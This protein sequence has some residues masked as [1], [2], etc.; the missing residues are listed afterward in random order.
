VAPP[1]ASPDEEPSPSRLHAGLEILKDNFEAFTVALI[2][3]LVIKHFCVEAFKIPTGSMY[4]TLYGENTSP[5]NVGDRILVD[6][7]A[8]LTSGPERW[9]VIVFRYPL[10]WS[11]HFI[12]RVAGL[13]GEWIKTGYGDLWTRTSEDE[14]WRIATKR[15]RVRD[16]L[17]LPVYPPEPDEYD[18]RPPP[19]PSRYWE[20]EGGWSVEDHQTLR[21]A[22]GDAGS[23]VFLKRIG[24]TT[25]PTSHSLEGD[26]DLVRDVRVL[27]TLTPQAQSTFTLSWRAAED[28]AAVVRLAPPGAATGGHVSTWNADGMELVKPL[29]V[30]LAPGRA[31]KLE[32]ECVDGEVYVHLDGEEIAHLDEAR[33]IEDIR[34]IQDYMQELKL[35]AEGGAVFVGDVRIERDV[36]YRAKE[37]YE[38][39]SGGTGVR[40]PEG[41]YF[42]LGDNTDSSSDSRAWKLAGVV[43]E[44]GTEFW[45]EAN[46]SDNAPRTRD[47]G[48]LH[49]LDQQGIERRWLREEEDHRPPYRD[50]PFVDRDL[51]VGR[52]FFIFWPVFPGFPGRAGF[53]H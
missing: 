38:L 1:F 44:D 18:E 19:E 35:T 23:A 9:D 22:G 3:A 33:S 14:P 45:Y 17:Y 27:L 4:P 34:D 13:G 6:K 12:K 5:Q 50:M 41:H 37:M 7:W 40:V 32:L 51:V 16:E 29:D 25:G 21:F 49:V 36:Y 30:R 8:Y 28:Q 53:I 42:M 15:R 20:V 24:R 46:S 26:G 48:Y 43:L 39:S 31:A 2:M 52:A 10:N 47:D 11:K